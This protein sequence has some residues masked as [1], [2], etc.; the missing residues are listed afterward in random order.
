MVASASDWQALVT[1][2]GLSGGSLALTLPHQLLGRFQSRGCS[3]FLEDL[4]V[5]FEACGW[6]ALPGSKPLRHPTRRSGLAAPLA[7]AWLVSGL[8]VAAVALGKLVPCL[9]ISY[10]T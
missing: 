2:S 9:K 3:D 5:A 7:G 10:P 8:S 1:S 6:R 4:S